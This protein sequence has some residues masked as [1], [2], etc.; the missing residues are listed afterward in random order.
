MSR[1]VNYRQQ[2]VPIPV[3]IGAGKTEQWYFTH[4]QKI[5]NYRIKVRPRIF[6]QEDIFQIEKKIESVI[7]DGGFAIAVFDAD[8]ASWND[9]ERNKLESI[10]RKYANNTNVILC[11]SLPSI[12]YWFLLHFV[13]IHR[14]FPTSASVIKELVMYLPGFDKTDSYLSQSKWVEML[15]SDNRMDYALAEAAKS[16]EGQSY[17]KLPLAINKLASQK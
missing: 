11:D 13:G 8:V 16:I 3:I 17:T 7:S 14:F 12:E 4:L 10:R 5:L 15:C 1:K 6:G 2:K 9:K